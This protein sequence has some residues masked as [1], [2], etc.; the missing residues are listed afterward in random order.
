[1][2]TDLESA[3]NC[4]IDVYHKYSLVK[5]NYHSIYCDDL[6]KLLQTECPKF[7]EKKDAEAWFKE[8]D[9]N[10]DDAINFQEFLSLVI[11]VG[12][13]AHEEIHK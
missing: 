13:A 11:K 12:L 10:E 3:M 2:L 4:L 9:V 1:M 6:K 7:L 8:L 5:G